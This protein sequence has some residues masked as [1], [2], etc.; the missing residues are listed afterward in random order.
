MDHTL[1]N[2]INVKCPGEE[3][4]RQLNTTTWTN[5]HLSNALGHNKMIK[6][7]KCRF[8]VVSVYCNANVESYQVYRRTYIPPEPVLPQVITTH[9]RIISK[10]TAHTKQPLTVDHEIISEHFCNSRV[11]K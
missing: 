4:Y 3:F 8:C 2:E 11:M 1:I 10:L 9:R 7:I 6:L 5:K